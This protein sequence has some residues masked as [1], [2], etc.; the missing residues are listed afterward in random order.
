MAFGE[1]AFEELKFDL[2]FAAEEEF[3]HAVF[4][5]WGSFYQNKHFLKQ[6]IKAYDDAHKLKTDVIGPLSEKSRCMLA[7]GNPEWALKDIQKC[8]NVKPSNL[9][10]R[11][12][13]IDCLYET[14]DLEGALADTY[15]VARI[16]KK[17][18]N[19]TECD[20]RLVCISEN[21][22]QSIGHKSGPMLLKMR[23]A[24]AEIEKEQNK[25]TGEGP[26]WKNRKLNDECDVVSII[27]S[28]KRRENP[29]D[30]LRRNLNTS[31]L[32][33]LYLDRT[34]DDFQFLV[35]MQSDKRLNLPQC[36][37]SGKR[38]IEIAKDAQLKV[39]K[40]R[41]MLKTR[42]PQYSKRYEMVKDEIKA[43][44]YQND[45][46]QRNQYQTRRDIFKHVTHAREL[47]ALK[48]TSELADFVSEI[49]GKYYAIKTSRLLPRKFEFI[50]ELCNIVAI[51]YL[52]DI[53]VPIDIMN[54]PEEDRIKY[55]LSA[56]MDKSVE[57][58]KSVHKFGDRPPTI[59]AADR[60]AAQ[61]KNKIAYLDKSIGLAK[62]PIEI[63]F[64]LYEIS[65]LYLSQY[66]FDATKHNARQVIAKAQ[67]CGN[68]P[69]LYL[70]YLMLSRAEGSQDLLDNLKNNLSVMSTI[71]ERFDERIR[72]FN[73]TGMKITLA[74]I[75]QL[76]EE[77]KR[78]KDLEEME[79]EKRKLKREMLLKQNK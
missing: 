61:Q 55:I 36:P 7:D 22:N 56:P 44:K 45:I 62:Y 75:D 66:R 58:I 31:I 5:D 3:Q 8:I 65:K 4:K 21:L 25:E 30:K 17:N 51:G 49:L 69:W 29:I 37:A 48:K 12:H 79:H 57:E 53:H 38:I 16:N 15:N 19:S 9:K 50:N 54:C 72:H 73:E 67:Q 14:N 59:S 40:W 27:E 70:G 43:K 20:R 34:T 10:Y 1:Y 52:S 39:E 18:F 76:K 60:L 68:L 77:M 13:K 64:H 47:M 74:K 32:N 28:K 23:K 2:E 11:H 24:V 46:L 41:N 26:L 42:Q 6:A 33:H 78:Q 35:D 71:A 63:C